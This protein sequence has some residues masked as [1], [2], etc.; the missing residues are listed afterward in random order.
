MFKTSFSIII[1]LIS[2]FVSISAFSE[3]TPHQDHNHHQQ[4]KLL[5]TSEQLEELINQLSTAERNTII[6]IQKEIADWP[7]SVF[8]EV[9]NYREFVITARKLAIEKY[10]KLSPEAQQ[11][12]E[13]E[14]NL[15]K[16]LTPTTIKFLESVQLRATPQAK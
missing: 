15:K 5:L 2:Y 8:D 7:K 12:I 3:E 9:S 6:K 13:K 10:N 4:K 16:Q 14:K 11:A 1:I